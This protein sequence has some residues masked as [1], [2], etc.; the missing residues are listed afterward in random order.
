[1]R[2]RDFITLAG[3]MAVWPLAARAQQQRSTKKKRI[4]VVSTVMK[5]ADMRIGGDPF[6][7]ILFNELKRLGYVEGENLI[8][9]RYSGEGV[10]QRYPD[11]V[12]EVVSTKPDLIVSASSGLTRIFKAETS[13][14]P[15]VAYTGDPIRFGLISSLAHPGGNIT[16]VS[17]DA[18]IEI[19][20]KRLAL[21]AEAVP[22]LANVV[23]ISSQPAWDMA[24]G[25]AAREVAQRLGISL[26]SAIVANPFGEADYR[27]AFS[28]IRRD[29]VDGLMFSDEFP[30]WANR[31]LLVQLVQ[32]TRLPAMFVHRVQ[33]EAGGLMS[34]SYEPTPSVRTNAKQI[35]EILRGANPADMPYVQAARFEL[36]INLKTA[37]ALGLDI[38]AGLIA[39]ADAVIE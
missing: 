25:N 7:D 29:Q 8:I 10:S 4:A 32:E 37:K 14:I 26:T 3:G 11:L 1:M 28:S 13:T 12:R 9:D 19:W 18:G 33:V 35:V 6:Y 15:I 39:P 21:L 36:V 17:V 27:R 34:Y 38:P 2:R 20:G 5:V 30:H 22:K 23:F 16:G 24:G 31:D